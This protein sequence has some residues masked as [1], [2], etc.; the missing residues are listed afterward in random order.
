MAVNHHHYRQDHFRPLPR[1]PPTEERR[2]DVLNNPKQHF[3]GRNEDNYYLGM[4]EEEASS[5]RDTHDSLRKTFTH[6][7]AYQP[8]VTSKV[9]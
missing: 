1:G 7:L 8:E 9:G 3:T 5:P 6:F 2:F 4:K